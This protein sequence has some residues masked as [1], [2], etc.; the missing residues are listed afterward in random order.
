M[1][2]ARAAAGPR[3]LPSDPT[4]PVATARGLAFVAL[5]AFGVLH[6]MAL[7]EPAEPNRALYALGCGILAMAGMLAA[8]RLQP[9]PAQAAAAGVLIVTLA[10]AILG[11]GVA[12]ELLRPD[13]W[14][15]L[16]SGVSRGVEALPGIRV[17]YRGVDQWTRTVMPLGGTVLVT[18]AAALAFWPRRNGRTGFPGLAL[19]LLVALYAIPAVALNFENEFLRGAALALLVLAFLR[20]EKL[21]V[22]DAGNAGLVAAGVAVLALMLAPAL[23]GDEPW[24]DYESW[25]LNAASARS[26]SF[27][28]DHDYGPLNWPRDGRELLR[29]RASRRAAYWKAE[30]LDAFDGV[31]WVQTRSDNETPATP[32]DAETIAAGTQRIRVTI[33][34]LSSD[35]FVAAGW[36]DEVDSPTL[37]EIPRGD[38]TWMASRTLRRGD[39]YEATVYTP[40]TTEEQRREAGPEIGRADLE[41]YR[42]LSLT[43]SGTRIGQTGAPTIEFTFPQFGDPAEPLR[44]RTDGNPSSMSQANALKALRQ[45]PY[46]RSWALSRQLVG[47]SESEEDYVQAVLRYLREGFSYSETPPRAARNLDGFLFDAKAG[48]CQQFS[49]SM[50]LLLRMGGVP[51]RVSTGFTSGSLDAKTREFVVRD[52]DAHSWV[53][54]WYRDIGWVTFDPTPADAPPRSQPNEGEDAGPIGSTA[55]PPSLGGGDRPS[56]PGRRAAAAEQSTWW[57]WYAIAGAAAVIVLV[58]ALLIWRG[59]RRRRGTPPAAVMLDE[60]ERALY[61]T[62]RHPGAGTTLSGL[63]ALFARSPAA[64]G[65]VRAVRELRYGGRP[66]APTSAQRRGLRV[67]LA[68]GGGLVGRLR[69][70]WAL[71][72]HP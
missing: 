1:G 18:L 59:R 8:A 6:W 62:R 56:D 15:E 43:G 52:L 63:E 34:N 27:S 57:G 5:A 7:L 20:L 16:A 36:A 54:V 67:E 37:R 11:G 31:R 22:G 42:E 33:R 17:P 66:V 4:L 23:D 32:N 14:G 39:A 71:P 21:R 61:R 65:Y 70:W 69:A 68:R 47:E 12:D 10:L 40:S 38:G 64:A 13:R 19:F 50:A 44:A 53:E 26:T 46:R 30:N 2:A 41:P 49:G 3:D 48:Y 24:W 58:A 25:A 9:R 45:G 51:A 55:G 29:V 60:L 28:W 72:P 35:D